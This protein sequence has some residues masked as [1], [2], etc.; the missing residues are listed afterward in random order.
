MADLY[1]VD[2]EGIWLEDF[3]AG[4]FPTVSLGTLRRAMVNEGVCVNGV[5]RQRKW[6]LHEGDEVTFDLNGVLEVRIEPIDYPLEILWQDE[7]AL[8]VNKP[9][10]I[11]TVPDTRA[12][13]TAL[14]SGAFHIIGNRPFVVHRL[15]R[16]TSGAIILAKSRSA[17]KWIGHQFEHRMIKKEY[18][19][20]VD[21][22][23]PRR[24]RV[25]TPIGRVPESD[26]TFQ[27]TDDGLPAETEYTLE[28]SSGDF[29]LVRARPLTGR[30]HQIR[31]HMAHI[32]HPLAVDSLYGRRT[33]LQIRDVIISRLTLHASRIVFTSPSKEKIDVTAP[34]PEDFAALCDMIA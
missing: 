8:V 9:A 31:I 26:P 11:G 15:D 19:A 16:G 10:G 22:T 18:L 4:R 12:A 21:G 29:S 25:D 6:R 23:P 28:K 7:H 32:G 1:F 27:A 14:L 24:G 3:L 17:A 33:A 30:T 2:L 20:V 34:P 13:D 5:P